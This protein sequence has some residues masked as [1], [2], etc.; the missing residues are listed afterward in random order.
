MIGAQ[1]FHFSA[2]LALALALALALS[3]CGGGGSSQWP[4]AGVR[5]SCGGGRSNPLGMRPEQLRCTIGVE[6]GPPD[7]KP[8]QPGCDAADVKDRFASFFHVDNANNIDVIF[9]GKRVP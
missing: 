9:S 8:A 1:S 4:N 2:M 7:A 5:G 3:A 6:S